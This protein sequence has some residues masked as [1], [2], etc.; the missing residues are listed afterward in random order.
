M[1][2]LFKILGAIG[3]L[4]ITFGV[5]TKNRKKQDLLYI[6][7]GITLESYSIY[8]KD[9]IFIILQI[10]FTIAALYDLY[11]TTH[12]KSW[13]KRMMKIFTKK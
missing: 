9:P 1:I 4:L 2:N 5:L 10:I 3:L 6:F 11:Q 12:E 7:G 8:L 13:I